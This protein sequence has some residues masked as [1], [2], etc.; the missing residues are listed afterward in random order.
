MHKEISLATLTS[1]ADWIWGLA[2]LVGGSLL[3]G[4]YT[5]Y[6]LSN[7]NPVETLKNK[8]TKTTKGNYLR[9]ALVVSQFAISIALVLATILIY[10]HCN[11]CKTKTWALTPTRFWL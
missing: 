3:S 9:K 8:L 11:T 6:T 1:T 4:M 7:F 2:L 5:A 10:Q